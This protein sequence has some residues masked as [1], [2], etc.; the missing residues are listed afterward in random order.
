ML[1]ALV[2][3]SPAP[4]I[5]THNT[6]HLVL[7]MHVGFSATSRRPHRAPE[8]QIRHSFDAPS[9]QTR[10]R[11]SCPTRQTMVISTIMTSMAFFLPLAVGEC[12]PEPTDLEGWSPAGVASLKRLVTLNCHHGEYNEVY[13]YM[14][15]V[16]Q[17]G[18]AGCE[19]RKAATI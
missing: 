4:P 2:L 14:P 15:D 19:N 18:E 11:F 13:T 9:L 6:K 8:K 1:L 12:R 16:S 7:C 3:H 5:R 17:T 10:L